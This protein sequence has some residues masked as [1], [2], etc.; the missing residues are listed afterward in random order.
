MKEYQE[1]FE[2][3]K[4]L[5]NELQDLESGKES[6]KSLIAELAVKLDHD[7]KEGVNKINSQFQDFFSLMFG[8]GEASLSLVAEKKKKI[9]LFFR[10][11]RL[12]C[13]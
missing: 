9:R 11:G 2:R 6:L 8:G 1:V 12:R 3:D 4:F 13:N 5:E 10:D 7:F